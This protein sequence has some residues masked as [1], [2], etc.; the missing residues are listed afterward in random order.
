MLRQCSAYAD[1][2]RLLNPMGR[3]AA[4]V[5]LAVTTIVRNAQVL[6][7]LTT[8]RALH[9]CKPGARLSNELFLQVR[10]GRV[11]HSKLCDM[12]RLTTFQG[13]PITPGTISTDHSGYLSCGLSCAAPLILPYIGQIRLTMF[14]NVCSGPK[15]CSHLRPAPALTPYTQRCPTFA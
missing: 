15:G 11:E 2:I 4:K 14:Q 8:A 3:N 6:N 7:I 12:A 1:P 10:Q 9:E 5:K 13:P